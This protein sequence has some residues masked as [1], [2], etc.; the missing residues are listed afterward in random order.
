MGILIRALQ[1]TEIVYFRQI[2]WA[3]LCLAME[4]IKNIGYD[5]FSRI[6]GAFRQNCD[7]YR[8]TWRKNLQHIQCSFFT[9]YTSLQAVEPVCKECVYL[10]DLC[11]LPNCDA[12]EV[13]AMR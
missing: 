6:I 5:A 9:K 8:Q 13:R 12:H 7:L 4:V 10:Y 11:A 3:G 2:A 1:N